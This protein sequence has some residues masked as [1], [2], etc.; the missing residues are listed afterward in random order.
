MRKFLILAAVATTL[1]SC[2][3]TETKKEDFKTGYIDSAV[4]LEKYE[5][6]KDEADK[7]KGLKYH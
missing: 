1:F 3:E 5:K 6:F 4:L 2:Q 7:L